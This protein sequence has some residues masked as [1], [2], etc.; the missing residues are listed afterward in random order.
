[1]LPD[2]Q[3]ELG[4]ADNWILDFRCLEQ[5]ENAFL[6]FQATEYVVIRLGSHRKLR[7]GGMEAKWVTGASASSDAMGKLQ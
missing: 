5:R 3:R 2:L 1:M 4:P 6:L 7:H